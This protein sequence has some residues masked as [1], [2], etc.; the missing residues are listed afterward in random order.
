MGKD[1]TKVIV[2][3]PFPSPNKRESSA[4]RGVINPLQ[5][6][7]EESQS[8]RDQAA[9]SRWIELAD[10]LNGDSR[11]RPRKKRRAA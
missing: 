3:R 9:V 6:S 4:V 5:P 7:A 1:K 11:A 10:I 2:W 8:E